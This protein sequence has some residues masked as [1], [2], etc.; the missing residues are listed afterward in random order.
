MV[1]LDCFSQSS[2]VPHLDCCH[3]LEPDQRRLCQHLDGAEEMTVKDLE[4]K[5]RI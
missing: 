4:G 2:G 1:R 3:Y 5:C